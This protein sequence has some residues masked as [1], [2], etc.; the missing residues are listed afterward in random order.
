MLDH[1]PKSTLQKKGD[2]LEKTDMLEFYES[3]QEIIIACCEQDLI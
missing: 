2:L 1:L 3:C